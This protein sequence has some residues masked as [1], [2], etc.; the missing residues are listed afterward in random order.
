ME[1]TKDEKEVLKAIGLRLVYLRKKTMA[2]SYEQF[3]FDHQISRVQYYRMEKGENF[4]LV[5]LLKVLKIHQ[6]S[7]EEFFKIDPAG[8]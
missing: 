7:I 5:S 1:I 2:K 4:T 6:I 3:A 8:E